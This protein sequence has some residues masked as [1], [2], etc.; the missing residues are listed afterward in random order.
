[1]VGLVL[2]RDPR[3]GRRRARLPGCSQQAGVRS[4]RSDATRYACA[5][6]VAGDRDEADDRREARAPEQD[7][8]AQV[9]QRPPKRGTRHAGV[10]NLDEPGTRQDHLGDRSRTAGARRSGA[11]EPAS[12]AQVLFSYAFS[13]GKA[14]I[15]QLCL[16][17]LTGRPLDEAE[18]KRL[19][20]RHADL[21]DSET[22][23]EQRNERAFE[24]LRNLFALGAFYRPFLHCF[25]QTEL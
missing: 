10:A 19:L 11:A 25:D 12:V 16:D 17:W 5:P 20:L 9:V 23:Y 8:G 15:R 21:P 6:R 1:L 18:G 3:E 24:R 14:D 2:D 7:C 22:P 13:A 4:G